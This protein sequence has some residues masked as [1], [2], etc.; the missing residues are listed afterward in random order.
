MLSPYAQLNLGDKIILHVPAEH[1][2]IVPPEG[3]AT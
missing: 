3:A 2:V 1:C